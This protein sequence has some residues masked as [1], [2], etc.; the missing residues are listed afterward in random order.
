MFCN[1][2]HYLAEYI[3]YPNYETQ[4]FMTM[5]TRA[6][7]WSIHHPEFEMHTRKHNVSETGFLSGLKSGEGGT[8]SVIPL[9]K[10]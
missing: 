1:T 3:T 8:Y 4:S 9:R 6:L 10:N 2:I 7:H 5:F